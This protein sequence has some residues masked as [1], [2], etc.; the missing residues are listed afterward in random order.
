LDTIKDFEHLFLN[1]IP[2]MDVR[3]PVEFEK[4]AFP[5]T[6]NKP[7]MTDEERT[8]VGTCY[9]EQGQEAAIELGHSLVKGEVKAGRIDAWRDFFNR[10]PNAVF[11][12]FRGGLRSRLTQQWLSDAG[13]KFPFV[14]GGYKAMRTYLLNHLHERVD[15]GNVQILSG[16]T[17]SGKTEVIHQWQH[18]IDLE[19]LANHR[20]SAFGKTETPQPSQINFENA[21]SIQWLK[22]TQH[23]NAPILFEDESRLIGRVAVLPEFLALSKRADIIVLEAPLEQRIERIRNDYFKRAYDSQKQLGTETAENYLDDFIRSALTRIQKRLGGVRF[24]ELIQTLDNAM[25][26]LRNQNEWQGFDD[27]ISGLLTDYYDPMYQYQFKAK[28]NN[29]LFAGNHQEIME[30]LSH[31]TQS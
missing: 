22:K 27:V 21:W 17:G 25:A 5:F 15:Q 8:L 14:E 2:M 26:S 9:K 18:S 7:L 1:D 13:L 23:T 12:C 30:W 28:G 3:A 11:Y 31:T 24:K 20:G 29:K 10:N 4:G 16:P 6:E 19:G